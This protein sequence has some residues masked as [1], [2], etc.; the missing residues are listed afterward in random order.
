MRVQTWQQ[1][2]FLKPN[3]NQYVD[4]GD[5]WSIDGFIPS[6]DGMSLKRMPSWTGHIDFV[7]DFSQPYGALYSHSP[8]QFLFVG[9]SA[10]H[11]PNRLGVMGI[12]Q[13]DLSTVGIHSHGSGAPDQLGGNHKQNL[14]YALNSFWWI[15][16]D[17][18]V[19]ACASAYGGT[20]YNWYTSE[21][22]IALLPVRDTMFLVND[23][24]E[25]WEFDYPTTTFNIYYDTEML[26]NVKH[27]FHYRENIVLFARHDDGA[28]AIYLVDDR[29]PATFRQL[30][31]MPF[32]TGTYLPDEASA[33]WSTP[34]AIHDDKLFFSPGLYWS[35][36]SDAEIVPI[37]LFDGSSV[38]MVELV[39]APIVPNAWGLVTWRDRLLLYFLNN[40]AQY[41]YLY[42]NGRFTQLLDGAYTLSNW[43]D[44]YSAG[45]ELWMP[46]QDAS[47]NE[48]WTRL[49]EY[50][51]PV[52][53]SS[54]LDMGRPTTQ[55]HLSHLA[56]IVSDAKASFKVKI[57]YRTESGSWTEAV[58]TA[59]ARHVVK[60]NLGVDF[61][62]L[63][64]RVTF[65]DNS[66]NDED[67]AL[68]SI[69]ATYSYGR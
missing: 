8:D 40:T 62:L 39:E 64:L 33:T 66:G 7:T 67:V 37:W 35:D 29:S 52:F 61:Y 24:D 32:E 28:H 27:A 25:I 1:T 55:K 4:K 45:G 10:E 50:E 36:D 19:Y 53:T 56:A 5:Y 51:N 57:E 23:D 65:T 68:Q 14:Y 48:G 21:N 49:D 38:E 42:H 22:A 59:N 17:Q 34:W 47:S 16:S 13:A 18:D 30:T 12:E 6:R 54:W 60:Q 26:I 11:T 44:L 69:A 63:Q 3:R 58:E 15:G 31:R 9:K 41:I 46:R 43:A 20:L 2:E